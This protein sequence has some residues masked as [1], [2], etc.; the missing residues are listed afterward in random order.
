MGIEFRKDINVEGLTATD[1]L[2]KIAKRREKDAEHNSWADSMLSMSSYV[3]SRL[4]KPTRSKYNR[5]DWEKVAKF[6]SK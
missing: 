3:V 2:N 6:A 4:P 1:L 5:I